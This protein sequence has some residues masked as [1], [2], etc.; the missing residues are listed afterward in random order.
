M[1]SNTSIPESQDKRENDP[2]ATRH[3]LLAQHQVPASF[4]AV[5]LMLAGREIQGKGP[6]FRYRYIAKIHEKH[7]E[8]Y[9]QRA[10]RAEI[11]RRKRE[12]KEATANMNKEEQ[13]RQKL[14]NMGFQ[15]TDQR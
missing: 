13:K 2:T 5:S 14:Q 3:L 1:S 8:I 10:V 4:P 6:W 15:R 12:E 7:H 11:R 9:K